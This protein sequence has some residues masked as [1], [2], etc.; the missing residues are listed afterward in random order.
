MYRQLEI[1]LAAVVMISKDL[2]EK[3]LLLPVQVKSGVLQLVTNDP[4]NYFALE[5]V[6]QQTGCYLKIMLSEEKPL[7]SGCFL[8]FCGGQGAREAACTDCP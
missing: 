3:N 8:L 5:E 6:R 7:Q 4:I 2:A 1:D